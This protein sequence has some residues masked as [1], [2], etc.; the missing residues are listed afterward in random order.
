M[1]LPIRPEAQFVFL[2]FI[3]VGDEKEMDKME[4]DGA[5]PRV[6]VRLGLL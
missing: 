1:L 3:I 2:L 6:T 4:N 5:S